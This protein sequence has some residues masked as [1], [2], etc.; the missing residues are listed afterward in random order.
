MI[1]KIKKIIDKDKNDKEVYKEYI[2]SFCESEKAKELFKND[3]DFKDLNK[4]IE[5]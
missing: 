3:D 4:Y 2:K 5:K 1:D